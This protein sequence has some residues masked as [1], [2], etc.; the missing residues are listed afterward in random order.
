MSSLKGLL[1][2]LCQDSFEKCMSFIKKDP[3]KEEY[4]MVNMKVPEAEN[5]ENE[6][7]NDWP[8]EGSIYKNQ[9]NETPIDVPI[10]TSK[11][12]ILVG[13]VDEESLIK[14]KEVDIFK[15][16]ECIAC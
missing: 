2:K 4:A 9:K 1:P 16:V 15:F 5:E 14:K 6:I 8:A 7:F 3:K 10:T 12:P 11:K 13:N